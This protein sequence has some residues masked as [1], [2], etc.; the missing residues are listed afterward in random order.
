MKLELLRASSE[1]EEEYYEFSNDWKEKGEEIV[2]YAA[3]LLDMDYKTWLHQA[4]EFEIVH[5]NFVPAHTYFLV[6][7]NKKIL[8]GKK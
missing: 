4:H 3:R 1:M 8:G 6:Q 5:T 7:E 2:P